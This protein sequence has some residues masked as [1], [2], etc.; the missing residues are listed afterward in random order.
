MFT[1]LSTNRQILQKSR[2]CASQL[3]CAEVVNLNFLLGPQNLKQI[4]ES[5]LDLCQGN[6]CFSIP[7]TEL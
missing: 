7:T 5:E 6:V 1:L 3:K 4:E 2:F